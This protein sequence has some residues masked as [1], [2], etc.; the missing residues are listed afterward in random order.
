MIH[1]LHARSDLWYMYHMKTDPDKFFQMRVNDAF[2]KSVDELRRMEV[3]LPTR[4]DMLR[5]LVERATV[6]KVIS[7][8]LKKAKP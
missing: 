8:N 6:G 2:L 3:D 1:S 4:A 5:R 7:G